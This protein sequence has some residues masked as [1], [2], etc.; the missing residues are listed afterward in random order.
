MIILSN[1][2]K[3]SNF[4]QYKDRLPKSMSASL[5]Y[6]FSCTLGSVPVSYVGSTKRHLYQRIAEHA[7]RSARTNSI[8]SSP[9]HSSIREHSATCMCSI[10]IDN[11]KSL[12]SAQDEISLRILESIHILKKRPSLND[13]QSAFPLLIL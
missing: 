8:L 7:G 13:Q 5:I 1:P 12:G 6:E 11:F 3:I 9:P 4:F 10:S 2:L